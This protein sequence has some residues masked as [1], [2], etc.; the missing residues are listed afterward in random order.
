MAG[1]CLIDWVV[2]ALIL[3][4]VCTAQIA[5]AQKINV[6][7]NVVRTISHP[8]ETVIDK[9]GSLDARTFPVWRACPIRIAAPGSFG[10]SILFVTTLT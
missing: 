6:C 2:R 8:A 9:I 10:G 7:R 5:F 3:L 4:I 1:R